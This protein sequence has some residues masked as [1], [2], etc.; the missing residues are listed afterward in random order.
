MSDLYKYFSKGELASKDDG[1]IRL[2][3]NFEKALLAYRR[4]LNMPLYVNSC[5]RT[6]A[7]NKAIG[8]APTS[9]HLTEFGDRKGT[10]AIDL[11]VSDGMKRKIMIE[12]ALKEGWSVGVYRT[13]IHIDRRVDLGKQQV[14]FY[15][16]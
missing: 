9:Y 12:L 6:P 14:V 2:D 16:G 3:P 10:M 7:H 1:T 11:A 5:C 13:F 15:G 8:G 4:K